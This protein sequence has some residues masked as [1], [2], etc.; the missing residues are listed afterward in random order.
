MQIRRGQHDFTLPG[1]I[2]SQSFVRTKTEEE[3]GMKFSAAMSL[4]TAFSLLSAVH[5]VEEAGPPVKL[6]TSFED[7]SPFSGGQIVSEH[8]TDGAKAL[9]VDSGYVAMDASQNWQ[10]YDYLKADLF[11]DSKEVQNLYVEVRDSGSTDYWTRMNYETVIPPGQSTLIL[12]VKTLY[13]GEKSRPGRGLKLNAITRLVFS[14]GEKPKAPLFIDNIRLERDDSAREAIFPEL[15]AFSFGPSDKPAYDGFKAVTMK[16]TYTKERG[17]GFKNAKPWRDFD[18]LQPEPLYQHFICVES[19]GFAVDVPNGKYHVFVNIDNPSG[20]WG[21][22]QIYKQRSISAQGQPVVTDTMDFESFKK[23]Y[24]RFWNVEDLPADNTFDKYQ[25]AY[26]TEKNF[27]VDVTDGQLSLEFQGASFACSLSTVIVYPLDKAAEGAKFLKYVEG[28]RR[29]FFDN[30]FKRILHQPSGDPLQPTDDD[31]KRGF[32]AFQRDYMSDVYY[33]DTPL[34]A[35]ITGKVEGSAFAGEYTPV[36][37]DFVPLKDLG[38]VTVTVGDLSGPG[39]IPSSAIDV[40]FASYRVERVTMEGSVYTIGPRL[41]MPTNTVACPK[42]VTRRFWMTVK[43]PADAKVGLYKGKIAIKTDSGSSELPIEFTV[44]NG[45]LDPVDIPAGPWGYNIGTPWY[46]DDPAATAFSKE[47]TAKSLRKMREYGFTTFSGMPHIVYH[48][49]KDGKPQLDF[50]HADEQMKLAKELGFLAVCT[51]G[52]G[53]TGIDAYS[54]DTAKMKA[55]GFNDYSEFIKAVYSEIQKH[56]DENG[57]VP[58]F[59]NLGDEPIG[60][61]LK[62]SAENAEAYRKAFPKGPPFFTA[63]SSYAGNDANDPHLRLAKALH[64]ADW[65]LHSEESVALLHKQGSD[66]AFYNGGNRWTYGDYMYKAVKQ[67]G[68]KFR[69]S[70][71]WNV[72]AGDPYYALD[73]REDDYAWCNSSP[74]GDLLP[75][76]TFERIREGLNDYRRLITLERL[77][78]EKAG[79]PAA[80][81]ATD[82]IEKRMAAFKLNQRDHNAILPH[83]DWKEFRAKTNAAINELRK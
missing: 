43:T 7:K 52:G 61:A 28:K 69:L 51:Y 15:H 25:K 65:N 79:T 11:T 58:V 12:P 82:L 6:I 71:H 37:L 46:N 80:Q 24:F 63:A 38:K 13:V 41:I 17:Y 39:T 57:W 60:D 55:A 66:W 44:H 33:N 78:K 54:Q 64:I 42:D 21:E 5:A 74:N 32:V 67:F 10:G 68:M 53:L 29:F 30:Y 70:W 77:A 14:V 50:S 1:R 35:E 34:K 56:A 45:S 49:F 83:E 3:T 62:R 59:Y 16:T 23:K 9:R 2:K 73:C 36:T 19:G 27:D 81:A 40:G 72:V 8:A 48:G 31:K 76:L 26:F 4:L 47:M 20:Y 22:Y 75:S 18:V